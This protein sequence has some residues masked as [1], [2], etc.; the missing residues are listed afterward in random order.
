MAWLILLY[1]VASGAIIPGWIMTI[2]ATK[3]MRQAWRFL[4]Q[5]FFTIP[6]MM[7][8]W[9]T[10]SEEVKAKY[11]LAYIIDRKNILKPYISSLA[12]SLF[13]LFI[14]SSFEW[15]FVSHGIV[16]SSLSNF[17]LSIGRSFRNQSHSIESGGRILVVF[18]VI[19]TIYDAVMLT[20]DHYS[21]SD[22]LS[23]NTFYMRRTWW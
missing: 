8:E 23:N 18:G 12:T 3:F 11:T 10:S 14:L 21:E 2:G 20:I 6:F 19:M 16:L 17:F 5:V 4:M 1:T 13:F 22:Y 9:R 7:Y 15:T